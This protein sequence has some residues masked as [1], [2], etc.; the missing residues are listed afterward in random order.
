MPQSGVTDIEDIV[1][2]HDV[3]V[4]DRLHSKHSVAVH[5]NKSRHKQGYTSNKRELEHAEGDS[6]IPG[7]QRIH[8]KTWG[9]S[10]NNSDSEY[11][12]G[13]LA[14]YGF[15]ITDNKDEADLWLLNSC[16]VKSPAEDHFR[17]EITMAEKMNKK[18]VL[19]GCV[20]QGQPN[21]QYIKGL[22]VVGV[23]Q[24]DRVVEVVEETLKGHTVR[25]FGPKKQN[26]KKA[27]GASLSLPK[28]RK[29][30]LIEIIAIN[31]GCLNQ[32]TYCKTKHARGD[33]GSYQPEEI[34]E[35]AFQSFSEGVV[36]IWL[37]SEDLGAYGHDIGVT[38][39]ELLWQ[40]VEV[41]PEGARMRLGMTNPPYIL[42]H[43]EEIVKILN[44]P[45]VYAF[46]HVPVQSASDS[47]L[48]DMRREYCC[49]DF[50]HVVD[51]I[52]ER[53][54]RVTIATDVICGF[55]T[56]T[57]K[58][59]QETLDLVQHYKFPSLFINQFF[60][61]PGTPAAK[62]ARVSPQE[63]KKR[64]RMMS[65]L[66]QSYHPY[67]HYLGERQQVLVTELSHDKQFFVGHNKSYEQVLVPKDE[68]LMGKMVEVEIIETGK[69]YMKGRL[70]SSTKE[71]VRPNVPL[72]LR[73]GEVSGLVHE[74]SN[75]A[76]EKEV[77][78]VLKAGAVIL[79]FAILWR[80]YGLFSRFR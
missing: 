14:S 25:M 39:P 11:M 77:S 64:T 45:R 7:S 43:L 79:G 63:V 48:M 54:P 53:V 34:I 41:I 78:L 23:Q 52:K 38:L 13:Q 36:E 19:A 59:F 55:P 65:D 50:R 68:D 10:H 35:R 24:I 47:V 2:S 12:A 37:T 66:F 69:H 6:Y 20:P 56:E 9:C 27:G 4:N 21:S 8:V 46:L 40:L 30:P 80:I 72:P 29:N 74:K 61:R 17:N 57:E 67:T 49:S 75:E 31:T 28:I 16:T 15:I 70:L 44:H 22:S 58:D 51:F 73:K 1:S 5:V 32:C 26:G 60:P 3:G 71:A 76:E 42:E 18:V 33:L 62:M